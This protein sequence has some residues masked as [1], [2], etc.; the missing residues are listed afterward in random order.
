MPEALLEIENLSLAF[1][2]GG[3][4]LPAIR[5]LS[6]TIHSREVMGLV[7]E[8]GSGKSTVLLAIM[9]YLPENAIVESGTIRYRGVDLLRAGRPA[10]DRIRGRRIG[11][12]YQDPGA[13]LNPSLTA[14]AQIAEVL[15][16]HLGMDERGARA[17]SEELLGLVQ[18]D[19]PR[20]VYAAYP[21]ELSG[22]M[23]QRAM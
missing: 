17:R 22:G 1:E 15:R 21:H 9:N 11:M 5:D 23:R 13:A 6:L 20:A 10:L 18:L 7:G 8:S 2:V 16:Q 4:R 3:R 12:V 19:D 14:G